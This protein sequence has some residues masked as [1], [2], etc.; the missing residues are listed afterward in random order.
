MAFSSSPQRWIPTEK[1][2]D[3]TKTS[4]AKSDANMGF[5]GFT[6]GFACQIY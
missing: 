5:A 4:N 3:P 6:E 1:L 2:E